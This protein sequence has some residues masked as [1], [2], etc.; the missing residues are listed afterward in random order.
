MVRI[1]TRELDLHML[2]KQGLRAKSAPLPDDEPP[3]DVNDLSRDEVWISRGGRHHSRSRGPGAADTETPAA[4]ASGRATP[5]PAHDATLP[6]PKAPELTDEI[7]LEAVALDTT[8]QITHTQQA[9]HRQGAHTIA[10]SRAVGGRRR[11]NAA[12]RQVA[13]DATGDVLSVLS[14]D[15]EEAPAPPGAPVTPSDAIDCNLASADHRRRNPQVIADEDT[16]VDDG[17][18]PHP[19]IRRAGD[20]HR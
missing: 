5:E 8:V 20:A 2:E 16:A 1:E 15:D 6:P 7:V 10:A 19:R 11:P 14:V 18:A 9:S 17:A 13:D 12:E 3:Q 4:A